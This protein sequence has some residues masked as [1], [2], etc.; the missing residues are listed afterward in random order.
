MPRTYPRADCSASTLSQPEDRLVRRA[1]AVLEQRLFQRGPELTQP[2]TVK[3]Y[4]QLQLASYKHEVFAVLFL[5]TKHRVLAFEVLVHGTINGATVPPRRVIQRTL[6]HNSA[7]IILAHNH[8]SGVVD[9]SSADR[10]LTQKLKELLSELDV[11]VLDHFIVG[12]G[13]SYSFAEAGLI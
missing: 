1:I 2:A 8:P 10:Y 9:P 13:E 12:S 4:L 5:D 6:E 3:K 11:R 7:A